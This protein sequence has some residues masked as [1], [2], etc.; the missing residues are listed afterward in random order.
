MTFLS[1]IGCCP[2]DRCRPYRG[3][4]MGAVRF[5]GLAPGAE[6][7]SPLRG[8][9]RPGRLSQNP[10]YQRNGACPMDRARSGNGKP[11][12]RAPRLCRV[13]LSD[14]LPDPLAA[15]GPRGN[16]GKSWQ[17]EALTPR[18]NSRILRPT[19]PTRWGPVLVLNGETRPR[20]SP[21][22]V[23]QTNKHGGFHQWHPQ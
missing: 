21:G 4:A 19:S 13:R 17:G 22:A 7:M 5:P 15:K 6:N 10:I 18:T 1:E 8:W 11:P 3:F 12:R 23:V 20:R 14:A 9:A 2:G 16:W